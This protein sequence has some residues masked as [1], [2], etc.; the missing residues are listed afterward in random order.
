[1]YTF[2]ILF[3]SVFCILST[4]LF[5]LIIFHITFFYI[6][7]VLSYTFHILSLSA[8]SFHFLSYHFSF[9]YFHILVTVFYSFFFYSL[10]FLFFILSFLFQYIIF[11]VL[12]IYFSDTVHLY[13]YYSYVLLLFTYRDYYSRIRL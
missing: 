12:P 1:M 8:R 2:F 3:I 11:F 13:G 5:L 6:S 4:L 7:H 9:A 10:F